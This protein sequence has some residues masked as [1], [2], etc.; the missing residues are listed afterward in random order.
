MMSATVKLDPAG[1]RK[2][3]KSHRNKRIDGAVALVMAVG[4]TRTE[5]SQNFDPMAMIA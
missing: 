3:D 5:T 4:A 1:N 2:L